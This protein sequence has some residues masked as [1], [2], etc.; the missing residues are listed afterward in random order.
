ARHKGN[1]ETLNQEMMAFYKANNINPMGG[2]L[3][4]FA[5]MPV[6]L[7][8]YQVLRGITR[9]LSDLGDST[10]WVAGRLNVGEALGG[11]PTDP[12]AFYPAYVDHGSE[13]FRDLS[14]RSEMVF[15]GMDLSRSATSALSE[16]VVAALPYAL[17]ILVVGVSSWFQQRQIR[18]RN[19]DAAVNPQMQMMMK[20]MPFFLPIISFQLDASLVVYFVVSNLYRI[21]QQA[22]ITRS[23]YGP[24]AEATPVVVPK[25]T[26]PTKETK[27]APSSKKTGPSSED[28]PANGSSARSGRTTAGNNEKSSQQIDEEPSAGNGS[29][30]RAPRVRKPAKLAAPAKKKAGRRGRKKATDEPMLI[31]KRPP[32][33]RGRG[34]RTTPPGTTRARGSKKNRRK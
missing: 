17:L 10:G 31:D 15:L 21:G 6:F 11:A 22:Y 27:T 23:L 16:S 33:A 20:V 2:C 4:L 1:R 9:R 14:N 29:G 5:Q 7:V 25:K 18:G 30:T 28:R 24:N 34:G 12:Q 8:L 3:P 26:K 13:I 32:A 19:P